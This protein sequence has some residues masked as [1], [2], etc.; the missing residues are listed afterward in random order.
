LASTITIATTRFASVSCG[1]ADAGIWTMRCRGP[2]AAMMAG[3]CRN[4]C[5]DGRSSLGTKRGRTFAR[6]PRNLP[7]VHALLRRQIEPVAGLDVEGAVPGVDV[8]D[9]AVDPVHARAVRVGE[10]DLPE[11]ALAP[12]IPP[13]LGV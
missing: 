1:S 4:C 9:D 10:H 12:V 11:Q 8:A 3:R 2:A 5:S 6:R 13:G 7:D